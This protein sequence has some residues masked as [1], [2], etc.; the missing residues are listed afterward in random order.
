[1]T[2]FEKATLGFLGVSVLALMAFAAST[3]IDRTAYAP[4][5]KFLPPEAVPQLEASGGLTLRSIQRQGG[6]LTVRSL[7]KT[8][9]TVKYDFDSV[10]AGDGDVP[11]LFLVSMPSDIGRIRVPEQRK[12]IFFQTVLPLILKVNQEILNK[13]RRVAALAVQAR[14]GVKLPA[15]DRLWLAAISEQYKTR[16]NDFATLLRRIDVVP[17]SLALA[18]AAEESGW[19]TSRFVRE[20][21]AL[22]GQWTVDDDEDG[23]LPRRRDRGKTHRIKAFDSLLDAVR[24]YTRNLNSHRAYRAM[25]SQRADMRKEGSPLNGLALSRS[26]TSYSARG[27]NYV[28]TLRVIIRAN[29]LHRLDGARMGDKVVSLTAKY[30]AKP[31]I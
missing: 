3:P 10:Q 28:R 14:R 6:G 9:S 23:L 15:E 8:F 7:R 25:R 12:E 4:Q 13:R 19:G 2:F 21:N 16:R 27:E 30:Q 11:P 18:Q 29:R 26:L 1:M 24:A 5:A 31:S 17:P 20:G 22:F